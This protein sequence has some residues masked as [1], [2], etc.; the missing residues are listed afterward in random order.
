MPNMSNFIIYFYVVLMT[1]CQFVV[2]IT[3]EYHVLN[4]IKNQIIA[5]LSA[6]H[7]IQTA[8]L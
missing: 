1:Y 7:L 5:D 4:Y 2:Y 3:N 6:L 8:F